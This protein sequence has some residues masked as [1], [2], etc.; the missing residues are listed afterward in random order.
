MLSIVFEV[1]E[2]FCDGLL[3]DTSGCR[4]SG[5]EEDA[6]NNRRAQPSGTYTE[7]FRRDQRVRIKFISGKRQRLAEEAS[8]PCGNMEDG[9][10]RLLQ[11]DVDLHIDYG[12]T[13][14]FTVRKIQSCSIV[15]L[16]FENDVGPW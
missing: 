9:R 3:S 10:V 2:F 8:Y 13:V 15:R 14:S 12:C 4:T 6:R 16:R 7:R 1:Y 5:R 11:V